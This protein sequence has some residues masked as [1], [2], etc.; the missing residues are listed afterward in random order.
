MIS[1]WRNRTAKR[2]RRQR[3]KCPFEIGSRGVACEISN[4]N[5]HRIQHVKSN[6]G[7]MQGTFHNNSAIGD[8]IND[9]PFHVPFLNGVCV[10]LHTLW[11]LLRIGL[12]TSPEFQHGVLNDAEA[13]CRSVVIIYKS[14]H[15]DGMFHSSV[16]SHFLV[17][18]KLAIECTFQECKKR[19]IACV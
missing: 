13:G 3:P 11:D 15:S 1:V 9:L 8:D 6:V 2:T 16:A 14:G 10:W 5:Q 7:V 12:R 19:Q 17:G 18:T 4:H